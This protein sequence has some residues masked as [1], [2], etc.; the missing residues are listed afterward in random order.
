MSKEKDLLA[1]YR[2]RVIDR[3]RAKTKRR[4]QM[5]TLPKP[6]GDLLTD[7]FKKDALALEKIEQSRALQAWPRMV[8]GATATVSRAKGFRGT[9]MM[10]VVND[11]MW[12][13]Q[14]LFLKSELLTKYQRA[15]PKL[16]ITNI[17]FVTE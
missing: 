8:G 7:Y 13:Q 4:K 3:N 5:E 1:L 17:F 11:P 16:K 9:Q 6:V 15:F 2:A 14:L 12:R 10:V